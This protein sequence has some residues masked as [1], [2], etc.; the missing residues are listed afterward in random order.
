[1]QWPSQTPLTIS[2]PT[3]SAKTARGIISPPNKQWRLKQPLPFQSKGIYFLIRNYTS[4]LSIFIDAKPGELC[5]REHERD[6]RRE[7]VQ[8]MLLQKGSDWNFPWAYQSCLYRLTFQTTGQ[9]LPLLSGRTHQKGIDKQLGKIVRLSQHNKTDWLWLASMH[10]SAPWNGSK[11][12]VSTGKRKVAFDWKIWVL[13]AETWVPSKPLALSL[14]FA[15]SGH[16]NRNV[17]R[18]IRQGKKIMTEYH[19]AI[20][21]LS[22][23]P[24]RNA[25]FCIY[26]RLND[27]DGCGVDA[28]DR[29]G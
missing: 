1:M 19:A 3:L 24:W 25:M 15:Q 4:S 9:G 11:L 17:T 14:A 22:V 27:D 28:D 5:C 8:W 29:S 26:P 7:I 18:S 12:A 6:T 21:A 23:H 13:L 2:S 16:A 20:L 10:I